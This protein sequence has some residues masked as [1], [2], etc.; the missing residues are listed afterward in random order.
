MPS[1]APRRWRGGAR[2]SGPAAVPRV[3]RPDAA[4]C[5]AMWDARRRPRKTLNVCYLPS[6]APRWRAATGDGARRRE[7]GGPRRRASHL[8][9]RDRARWRRGVARGR[10]GDGTGR[11]GTARGRGEVARWRRG[12]RHDGDIE[13]YRYG[14]GRG[15]G[16]MGPGEGRGEGRGE[17]GGEGCERG[18]IIR[19]STERY[20]G[21]I[22]WKYTSILETSND[23]ECIS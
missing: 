3:G 23:N 8:P 22:R 5:A 20:F 4:P 2:G 17:G 16:A 7:P 6:G 18:V 15:R 12:A 9:Q 19:L 10:G 1:R 11:W 21:T 13:P 14:T